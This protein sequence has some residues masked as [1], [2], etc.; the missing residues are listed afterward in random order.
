MKVLVTGATGFI[1]Q[2]VVKNLL[3]AG[4]EVV[5][6]TRNIPKGA[7]KLGNQCRYFQWVET[8]DTEPPVEAFLGVDAVINLMGEGIAEKRWDEEQKKKIYDSRILGTRMLIEAIRKLDQKPK[9]FISASAIGIYGDRQG[10]EITEESK[11][12]DDFLASVCR[13]WEAEAYK[14][15]AE[16]LRVAIVRTGVVLGRGGGA[17]SKMLPIFKLGLGGKVGTGDQYMSWIHVE[18]LANMYV[19]AVHNAK[20]EGIYNGTAPYPTTNLFFTKALGKT[21]KR[22]TMVPAPAFALKMVFGEMS[23]VLLD[24]QKVLP[25]HFKDIHFRYRYPTLE[26][27]LK[28]TAY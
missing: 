7:L 26:M 23:Q 12:A 10:E 19:E 15:K 14:A 24:G 9:A 18:D 13:D 17:L 6:L 20:V 4:D 2:R 16:G 21:L 3:A 11:I 25:T 22:P 8:T 28:E 27:A 1:G 5:V